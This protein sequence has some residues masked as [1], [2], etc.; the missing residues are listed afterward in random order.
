M[1]TLTLAGNIAPFILAFLRHD[2]NSGFT[3]VVGEKVNRGVGYG[4]EIPCVYTFYGPKSYVKELVAS[5]EASVSRPD[6]VI[7]LMINE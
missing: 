6:R 4:L 7:N 1:G 3:K 5:L 2:T